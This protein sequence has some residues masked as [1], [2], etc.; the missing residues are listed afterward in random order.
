MSKKNKIKVEIEE[1]ISLDGIAGVIQGILESNDSTLE[2]SDGN[3]LG[4]QFPKEVT[5]RLDEAR[6]LCLLTDA[7]LK[8][9][10]EY[11]NGDQSIQSFIEN[12]DK[13]KADLK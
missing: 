5:D 13:L 11:L 3:R 8:A 9:I 10:S 4:F 2:D 7:Y 1:I 6:F 12:L